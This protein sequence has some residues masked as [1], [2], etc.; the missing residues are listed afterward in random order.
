MNEDSYSSKPL[1]QI[2]H[3]KRADTIDL[4]QNYQNVS[5]NALERKTVFQEIRD[6]EKEKSRLKREEDGLDDN[7]SNIQANEPRH[8][9]PGQFSRNPSTGQPLRPENE[10]QNLNSAKYFIQQNKISTKS[11]EIYQ[12]QLLGSEKSSPKLQRT[13]EGS[14]SNRKAPPHLQHSISEVQILE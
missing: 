2:T 11:N 9:A 3:R 4:T 8:E 12:H 10:F 13:R 6:R 5:G 1:F 7:L 14:S